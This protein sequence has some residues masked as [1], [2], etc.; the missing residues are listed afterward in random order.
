MAEDN[1]AIVVAD[2]NK[3]STYPISRLSANFQPINQIEVFEQSKKL[4]TLVAH[5]KLNQIAEQ[6]NFLQ[7]QAREI[8]MEAETNLQLHQASCAFEKRVGQTYY[9]YERD[10]NSLYFSL[11]SPQ[12]WNN[13][14]P[15]SFKGAFKLEP[16]M[17]WSSVV[18]TTQE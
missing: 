11:L 16:D 7:N 8:I 10:V 12:D 4:L 1:K 9:L 14:P 3:A 5:T 15:H 17:S 18:E 2:S 13:N 6:I